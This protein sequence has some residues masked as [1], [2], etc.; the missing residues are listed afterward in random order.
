MRHLKYYLTYPEFR[1]FYAELK[2]VLLE[3]KKRLQSLNKVKIYI[4]A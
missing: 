2:K 4:N 1:L 3:N